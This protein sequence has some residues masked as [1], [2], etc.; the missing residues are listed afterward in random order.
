MIN[1]NIKTKPLAHQLQAVEK[2]K[3]FKVGA[4][5]MDMGTGKSLSAM[6]LIKERAHK[7]DNVIWLTPVSLK[8]NVVEQIKTHTDVSNDDIYMFNDKTTAESLPIAKWNIIGIESVSG[9]DRAYLAFKHLVNENS[10][11]IV[12]ESSFIKGFKSKRTRRISNISE[13]A[14]YRLIMTGTPMSQGIEDLFSQF[15]FLS[16]R[17]LKYR[18]WRSF[19]KKHL[20]YSPDFI[21]KIEARYGVE[22]LAVKLEPFS[23]Q[24]KKDECLTL[25]EKTIQS[26]WID[27]TPTQNQMY[28]VA[29]DLF[30][31]NIMG[32]E[33]KYGVNIE[34]YKLFNSLNLIVNGLNPE[35]HENISNRKDL[36][37]LAIIESLKQ[38]SHIIVWCNYVSLLNRVVQLTNGYS[39]SGQQS[40]YQ[41]SILLSKWR[42]NGGILVATP[43]CGGMGLTLTEAQTS[44]FY[45]HSW[46]YA[47]RLQSEDR[48]HRIGQDKPVKYIDIYAES[49]IEHKICDSIQRKE[50]ALQAFISEV[51]DAQSQR[52]K[53][54]ELINNI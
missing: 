21:G 33:D 10:L 38:E 16:P 28:E 32:C 13:I 6:M 15:Y 7:I 54:K 53:L 47:E 29:K 43:G 8:R 52:S 49:G 19:A 3:P 48:I 39:Y 36:E 2:I 24:I 37:L 17:I 4:F 12:D 45:S 23:F 20:Q 30:E 14:R 51:R 25:P 11:V 5:F 46:K 40:E 41:R 34:V 42:E 31:M 18:T 50:D 1:F 26:R 44:I 35:N 9:S 27:L 22:E